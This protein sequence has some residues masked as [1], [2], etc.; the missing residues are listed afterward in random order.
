MVKRIIIYILAAAATMFAPVKGSDVGNLIPVE[1]VFVS[2]EDGMLMIETD[3]GNTG[4]GKTTEEAIRNLHDTAEGQIFLDTADYLLVEETAVPYIS[5]IGSVLKK[6]VRVCLA[7]KGL[8]LVQA[9]AYLAE[10]RPN[11]TLKVADST[12]ITSYLKQYGENLKIS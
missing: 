7:E 8:D 1:L 12:E 2:V 6:S 3:T 9:S 4:K 10:H 5:Q 11:E